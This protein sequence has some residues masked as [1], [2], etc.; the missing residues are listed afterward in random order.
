MRSGKF[1]GKVIDELAPD[2]VKA[3]LHARQARPDAG[4]EA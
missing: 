1:I 3:D 2:T 4:L